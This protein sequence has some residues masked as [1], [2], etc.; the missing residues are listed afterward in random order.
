MRLIES[1]AEYYPKANWQRCTVHFY[2]S[3]FSVV[4]RGKMKQVA[5]MLKAIHAREDLPAAREKAQAVVAK[6]ELLKLS[7]ANASTP[8]NPNVSA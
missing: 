7:R 3:V 1:L 6:L 2:R 5:G 8:V 4:P